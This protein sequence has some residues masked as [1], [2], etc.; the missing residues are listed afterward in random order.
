MS[1]S[2]DTLFS[3]SS[4][5]LL[6]VLFIAFNILNNLLFGGLRLDLTQQ[7]LYTLSDGSR[8]IIDEIEEPVHFHFFFSDS[9]TRDVPSLRSYSR[10]VRE[11]LEEYS[12]YGGERL[13][14]QLIDPEPFSR[15]E[16]RAAELGL[17]AR[18]LEVG[19]DSIYFGLAAIDSIDRH[20]VIAFFESDREAVLEYE[21][22][23]LLHSLLHPKKPLVGVLSSLNLSEGS[24][25]ETGGQGE[26]VMLRQVRQSFRVRLLDPASAAVPAD[27]DVMLAV[28]PSD[29]PDTALY[30]LD[31][32]LIRGGKALV[33]ADPASGVA[34]S[35]GNQQSM[36]QGASFLRLLASW[37]VQMDTATVAAD[38]GNAMSVHIGGGQAQRHPAY[39]IVTEQGLS[40]EDVVTAQLET[41]RVGMPGALEAMPGAVTQLRPLVRTGESGGILQ[42][43]LLNYRIAAVDLRRYMSA[44]DE[45]PVLAALISGPASSA[46]PASP[47]TAA[48]A[49]EHVASADNINL[50][51]FADT[52]ML[53]DQYWV[54]VG[55]LLG[56]RYLSATADNGS[57]ILNALDYL[58]GSSALITVR[59]RGRYS[60][61]FT[62]VDAIRREADERYR[63]QAEQLETRLRQTESELR[64][65][66]QESKKKN[67]QLL[68]TEKRAAK[69]RFESERR[70]IRSELREVRHQLNRDIESLGVRL[71]IINIVVAPLA[72]VGLL[73]GLYH[74]Q[75]YRLR[76]RRSRLS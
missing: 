4:Y 49:V 72:L 38:P 5:L 15:A 70:R 67:K 44:S 2:K 25:D 19:G 58:G 36:P 1:I 68:N 26:W 60:R 27:V 41:V 34:A 64:R 47:S 40:R 37:G 46:F 32:H 54:Q 62:A 76:R 69:K 8:E 48:A 12:S 45:P 59:S 57:F 23:R 6:A 14:L 16:E 13:Q 73:L 7:G 10:Q 63:A 43:S 3:S 52:D 24:L 51:L 17:Q 53:S 42:G 21:I 61:P 35:Q 31:Q 50:I 29:L 65:L 9:V 18:P 20:Q 74:M 75:A 39:F 56:H 30:V 28:R 33:F 55:N 11:L 66:N 22:S 71:G